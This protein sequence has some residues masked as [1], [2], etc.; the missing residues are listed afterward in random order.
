MA[1]IAVADLPKAQKEELLCSYAALI[2]H[3]EGMD[4]TADEISKL[5]KA[6]GAT[7]EPYMPSLFSR[8]LGDVK[9]GDLLSAA[10]SGSGG[11]SGAAAPAGGAA[12]AADAKAPEPEPEE[13]EEEDDMGFSLFD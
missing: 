5:I 8:A 2:L 3:D 10:G 4:V 9:I 1:A 11:S 13:E 12:P 7:V 6:A